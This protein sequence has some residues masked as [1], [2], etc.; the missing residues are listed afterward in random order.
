MQRMSILELLTLHKG[1][2][3]APELGDHWV[4]HN[5]TVVC[6]Y[7]DSH[8]YGRLVNPEM[9]TLK[10]LRRQCLLSLQSGALQSLLQ[11]ALSCMSSAS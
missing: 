7:H 3:C 1:I 2:R 4:L 9:P 10:G 5:C 8:L 11:P 6:V